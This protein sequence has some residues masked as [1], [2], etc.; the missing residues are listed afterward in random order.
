VTM[1]N[2]PLQDSM[3]RARRDG[4]PDGESGIFFQPK[5]D[6]EDLL[7]MIAENRPLRAEFGLLPQIE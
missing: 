7:E 2:A 5:L 4:L 3:A 1:A 6:R